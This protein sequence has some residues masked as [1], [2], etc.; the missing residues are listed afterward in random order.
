MIILLAEQPLAA[1]WLLRR[2]GCWSLSTITLRIYLAHSAKVSAVWL[3]WFDLQRTHR[4]L[5]VVCVHLGRGRLGTQTSRTKTRRAWTLA[6]VAVDLRHLRRMHADHVPIPLFGWCRS[7]RVHFILSME[8]LRLFAPLW[9][10]RISSAIH[11]VD[12]DT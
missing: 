11:H 2:S 7:R 6:R 4:T 9:R 5:L 10:W 3:R 8:I 12:W 1:V